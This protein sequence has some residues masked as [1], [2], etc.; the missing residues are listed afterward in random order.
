MK[1]NNII[2]FLSSSSDLKL[3]ISKLGINI[4]IIVIIKESRIIHNTGNLASTDKKN[5][6]K[7]REDQVSNRNIK[8][9]DL[10]KI[11]N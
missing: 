3:E 10:F 2:L 1:S 9:F 5:S 8:K 7:I 4:A 6:I 11:N